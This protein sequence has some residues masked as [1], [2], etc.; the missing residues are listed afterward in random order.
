MLNVVGASSKRCD[1]LQD[2]Q[3]SIVAEALENGEI[4]SGPYMNQHTSLKRYVDTHWG[5]HYV[6]LNSLIV[7][8]KS[9]IEVLE[10]IA[11][12]GFSSEQRFDA[13][14]LL[15]SMQSFDFVFNLHFMRSVLGVSNEL[16]KALQ[17]KDQDIMNAM[18]LV[19]ICKQRLQM[20]R[21][22]GWDSLLDQVSSFCGKHNIDIRNMDDIYIA[23]GRSR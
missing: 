17:K 4:S 15:E 3:A 10:K 14:N 23:R 20:M 9:T 11:D 8:F 12:D 5:S 21:E 22:N 19:K 2:K 1:M 13:N 18:T 7:M 16:S 6:T